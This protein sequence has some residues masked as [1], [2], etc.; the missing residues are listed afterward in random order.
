MEE[1]P[2]NPAGWEADLGG[3]PDHYQDLFDPAFKAGARI[4]TNSWGGPPSRYIPSDSGDMDGYLWNNKKLVAL[5]AAGNAG[6][7]IDR[8]HGQ[9]DPFSLSS[10]ATAKNWYVT[11]I[12]RLLLSLVSP[13]MLKIEQYYCRRI[14]DREDR[15]QVPQR[16]AW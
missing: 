13:N 16:P 2:N 12:A 3:I 7:D 5:F 6:R 14:R 4:H 9:V 11:H 15:R 1:Y 10:Q 8:R